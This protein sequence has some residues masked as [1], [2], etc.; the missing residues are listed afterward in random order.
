[1]IAQ[2]ILPGTMALVI[3]VCL[4]SSASAVHGPYFLGYGEAWCGYYSTGSYAPQL[5]Y[6][7]L[8]PPV[9]YSYPVPR[10]YGQSPFAYLPGQVGP[11]EQTEARVTA[12]APASP[13]PLRIANPYVS[14]SSEISSRTTTG[15]SNLKP[16]VVHP[17]SD[18]TKP[19]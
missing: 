19:L 9:Y 16:L 5:P 11:S 14:Q 17:T 10:T 1:M 6:Y 18:G 12:A 15:G 8:Y 4:A 7:S 13:R 2:R 3:V